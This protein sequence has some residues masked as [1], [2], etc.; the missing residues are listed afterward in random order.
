M[1]RKTVKNFRLVA[2]LILGLSACKKG[3]FAPEQYQGMV[4][5]VSS[6]LS[7]KELEVHFDGLLGDSLISA[8]ESLK[9]EYLLHTPDTASGRQTRISVYK[10]GSTQLVADTSM[11]IAKNS[12]STLK[13]IY[14]DALQLKGFLSAATVPIDSIKLQVRFADN[15]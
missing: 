6:S 10:A 7:D 5:V 14:S 1:Q 13:V 3:N 11:Y 2:W 15:T 12:S 9:K 4:T 8:G